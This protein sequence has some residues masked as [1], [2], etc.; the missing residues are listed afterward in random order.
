[1]LQQPA[2]RAHKARHGVY[3]HCI[4]WERFDCG[5]KSPCFSVPQPPSIYEQDLEEVG[6]PFLIDADSGFYD[7]P[8][9]RD[10]LNLVRFGGPMV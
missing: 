3:L 7:H 2:R 8:M 6:V 4:R 5:R 10:V 9:V 1:M